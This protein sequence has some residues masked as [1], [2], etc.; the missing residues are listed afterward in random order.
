[1]S[2]VRVPRINRLALRIGNTIGLVAA[3]F[4]LRQILVHYF[5]LAPPPFITFY[6]AVMIVALL[7]GFWPGLLATT[8][9]AL[10]VDYWI[11]PPIGKWTIA[12]TSDAVSLALFMA[13]GALLCGVAERFRRNHV[14]LA[15]FGQEQVLLRLFIEHAPV[16]LAMF[17]SQ[18][19][20]LYA[21]QRWLVDYGLGDRDLRGLSHYDVF[22]EI[23][24]EWKDAH[25]R[26][27]AGEVIR[28][29]ADRF[30]RA[31]GTLQW[32]R[33]EL[34]PWN[35]AAGKVGGIVIFTEDISE[36]KNA[37]EA[38]QE[39]QDKL[40][41]I[42]GSAMDAII[43]VNEQ[44]RIVVFNRAAEK[45][46][47]CVA[48]EAIGTTLDRFIPAALRAGHSEHIRR[49]GLEGVTTRS[50][51]SPAILTALRT[52][53]EEFPIEATIS[54]VQ[55]G[56][57][58]LF[59]VILRDITERKRAED[60][61]RWSED[62]LRALAARSQT[63]SE[64]ERLRIARELHDQLGLALTSMKMD[65]NWIL[66]KHEKGENDWIPMVHDSIKA[67]DS[68]I[69]LVRRLATELRPRML[70]TAGLAAAIEWHVAE[71]QRHTGIFCTAQVSEDTFGF[72]SDQRIE[73]F[74]ICQEALTNVARHSRAKHVLVTLAREQDQA[75]LT[76]NDDGV[77]FLV[78]ELVNTPAL[79]I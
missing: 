73:V 65:L 38:M 51:T 58:K 3:A 66:R 69:V 48:S 12:S 50:M 4:L 27:L 2:G 19:R 62:Q 34:R 14:R 54:H 79:G 24:A 59:T 31:D 35:D 30:E 70:D 61:L 41:G 15:V 55:A 43:S 60:K 56:G 16:A 49:F 5:G 21:S 44:Q 77:G 10:L 9:S 63:A 1:M 78:D 53:G 74:R 23:S 20:Y 40:Q 25:R 11:L 45:I 37:E 6:P 64:R 33:W 68:T 67:V 42:V 22:P 36:R 17:D 46:F 13:T 39:S 52:G 7:G 75:I 57:E 29:E 18:M 28:K 26:G 47:G 76:V 8:L 72:S 32:V 71:F